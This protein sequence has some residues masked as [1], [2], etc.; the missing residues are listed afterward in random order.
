MPINTEISNRQTPDIRNYLIIAFSLL[1]VIQFTNSCKSE[2]PQPPVSEKTMEKVIVDIQ[3]AE[4]YSLGMSSENSQP[5]LTN[6]NKNTDSLYQFYSAIL[7]HYNLSY[8]QFKKAVDW[9]KN[10]P[11]NMDTLLNGAIEELNRQKAKLGLTDSDS[12]IMENN[13]GNRSWF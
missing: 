9:Y 2:K 10:H 11:D 13:P 7:N 5:S 3:L 1:L 8:E 4:S 12:A 6:F